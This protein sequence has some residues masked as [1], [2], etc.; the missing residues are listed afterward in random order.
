MKQMLADFFTVYQIPQDQADAILEG[1]VDAQIEQMEFFQDAD[2]QK[3]FSNQDLS[4]EDQ[5]AAQG[6][7]DEAQFA[8]EQRTRQV[9]GMYYEDYSKYMASLPQQQ[10]LADFSDSLDVPLNSATRDELLQIFIDESKPVA[11]LET[12]RVGRLSQEDVMAHMQRQ[13]D[14]TR[15]RNERIKQRASSYL[16][17]E[18]FEQ[19]ASALDKEVARNEAMMKVMELSDDF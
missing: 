5:L 17:L 4:E 14:T 10:L 2:V 11:P 3:L 15:E 12:A 1:L 9:L 18:Q 6:Y 13:I 16:T 19:L 7:M 8:Q